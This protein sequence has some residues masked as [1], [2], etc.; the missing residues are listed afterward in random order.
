MVP[1]AEGCCDDVVL[2][3]DDLAGYLGKRRFFGATVGRY[4][5]RI[6]NARFVLDGDVVQLAANNGPNALHG[7]LDGFDR[8]LWQIAEIEDGRGAVGDTCAMSAPTARRAIPVGWMFASR[9]ACRG[10]LNCRSPST[11]R[12]DRP[13]I[14][15][16]T[17]HSF[18]NLEGATSGAD[19]LDHRLTIAA[20]RFLAIDPDA[21]PL[22]GAAAGR[23]RHA[24]RFPQPLRP[25][26]RES[27]A[28]MCSCGTAEG[29]TTISAWMTVVNCGLRRGSKRRDRG[30]SSNSSPISLVFSSIRETIS[31]VR[32]RES[33]GGCTGS[34]MRSAL[35][36]RS[37]PMRP[38][39]RTFRLRASRRTASISTAASIASFP[40][41]SVR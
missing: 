34:R 15:N 32:F 19:I 27:A 10:P 21:I 24:F 13:T 25:S 35:N 33:E 39:G 29:T 8:Q 3:H 20:D 4:A 18:F 37:G 26:A 1:D 17:N 11:A 9:I 6:A 2:G 28:T 36:R 23:C 40:R 5:N 41:G 22:A 38:T 14:V 7:G 12:T 31:T 30:E 16:L